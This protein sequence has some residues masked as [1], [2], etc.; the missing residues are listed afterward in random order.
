M[1]CFRCRVRG[2]RGGRGGCGQSRAAAAARGA[3]AGGQGSA[4]GPR[5]ERGGARAVRVVGRP[6]GAR[7]HHVRRPTLHTGLPQP[8]RH[9]HQS[10]ARDSPLGQ[11]AIFTSVLQIESSIFRT[12]LPIYLGSPQM[13]GQRDLFW[14]QNQKKISPETADSFRPLCLLQ[15]HNNYSLS[16]CFIFWE[17]CSIRSVPSPAKCFTATYLY[18]RRLTVRYCFLTIKPLF[19]HDHQFNE[20]L[21][22]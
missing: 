10:S 2:W 6:W 13:T 21:Y 16:L 9:P 20:L 4:R 3:G 12:K 15:L 8:N 18:I 14:P 22:V 19:L 7:L 1:R 5:R 11:F 17:N